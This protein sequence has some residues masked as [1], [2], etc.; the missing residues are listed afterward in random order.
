ML[1]PFKN[2]TLTVEVNQESFGG[3]PVEVPITILKYSSSR[4]KEAQELSRDIKKKI[5]RNIQDWN[6]VETMIQSFTPSQLIELEAFLWDEAMAYAET[7]LHQKMTREFITSRMEPTANYHRRQM[8]NEP[9]IACRAN[10][11]IHSNPECASRKLREHIH[12]IAGVF[13]R[14]NARNASTNEALDKF[15]QQLIRKFDLFALILTT[16]DGIPVAALS[17]ID[18]GNP[19]SG[20]HSDFVRFFYAHL[21]K[22]IDSKSNDRSVYFNIDLKAVSQKF[23]ADGQPMI[24]TLLSVK[25]VNFDVAVFQATMGISRIFAQAETMRSND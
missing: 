2:P 13:D 6:L 10:Y 20:D 21:Q 17:D 14:R 22:Y 16:D 23:E 5:R 11:C 3:E 18:V 12:A 9:L 25:D 4:Q 8:C 1:N 24:I 15:L 7:N 19:S